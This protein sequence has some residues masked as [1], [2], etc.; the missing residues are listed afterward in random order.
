MSRIDSPTAPQFFSR[1][2]QV[3]VEE[4]RK[5]G[6]IVAAYRHG[7]AGI[8]NALEAGVQTIEYGTYINEGIIQMMKEK[9]AILVATCAL[10]VTGLG[11]SG[12]MSFESYRKLIG[13]A[14]MHWKRYKTAVSALS[15]SS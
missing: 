11:H 4:A 1:E 14:G 7:R 6:M 2:L 9:D 10:A 5:V 13:I 15:T 12:N 8:I 3:I